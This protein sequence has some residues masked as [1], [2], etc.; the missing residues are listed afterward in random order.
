MSSVRG[1]VAGPYADAP[2]VRQLHAE[3]RALGI[4]PV[5]RWA[6][7]ATGPEAL[8]ELSLSAVRAI[9][10]RNDD[11]L[12]NA[13]FAIVLARDGAGG[14]M[15]AEV[16]LALDSGIPVVWVGKRRPLTAYREGVVRV[17]SVF[18]ALS[19]AQSVAELVT[20]P[21]IVSAAWARS[22]IW[23]TIEHLEGDAE[24]AA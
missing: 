12:L 1:Y 13:H 6:E 4:R 3:L 21:W 7:E 11:D 19:F 17:A 15:F 14:E 23:S 10:R 2:R 18:D 16:R 20:R 24:V 8:E 9:A 22:M 5:S